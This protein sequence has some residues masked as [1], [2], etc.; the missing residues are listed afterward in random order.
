MEEGIK[1]ATK[2][3]SLAL[4]VH[5]AN[6]RL[7][8]TGCA[9]TGKT[10]TSEQH[11]VKIITEMPLNAFNGLCLDVFKNFSSGIPQYD[12]LIIDEAQDSWN[13]ENAIRFYTLRRFKGL[14]ANAI[15]YKRKPEN[16]T[17]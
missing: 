12:C 5:D 10:V 3:Q 4:S 6:H 8:I 16:V 11:L 17:E 7:V 2:E 15:L 14:E 1:R 9:G 13:N